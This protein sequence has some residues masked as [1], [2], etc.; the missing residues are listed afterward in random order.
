MQINTDRAVRVRLETERMPWAPSPTPG[1]ERRMLERDG[2]E[3]ARATSLVRFAAGSAFPEHSHGAGEEFLV[4]DGVFS[5]EEGDFPAGWYV[6][7][8]PGSRHSPRSEP[9][10]TI[11]VKLRQM[12][13]DDRAVVR[14]DTRTA[15]PSPLGPGVGEIALFAAPGERVALL[16][17]E[18]GA[19][20][21][22]AA[23]GVEMFLVEGGAV[24][25]GEPCPSGTWLRTPP[26]QTVDVRSPTG[27]RIYVKTGH[28]DAAGAASPS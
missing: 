18:P 28:L 23:D 24:I 5:D 17:L 10:C 20:W 8:P 6:R 25:D 15:R 4:L 16:V 14:I 1:V 12:A 27:A 21:P 11:L 2:G 13:P 22:F 19:R 9:G 3:V 26:G 7:N